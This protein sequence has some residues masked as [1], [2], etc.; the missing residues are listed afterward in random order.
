MHLALY[1]LIPPLDT[2]KVETDNIIN[3]G[4]RL[5]KFCNVGAIAVKVHLGG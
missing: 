3:L 1:D 2:W 5:A 4:I